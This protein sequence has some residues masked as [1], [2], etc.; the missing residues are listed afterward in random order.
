MEVKLG[1]TEKELNDIKG[2]F[3]QNEGKLDESEKEIVRLRKVREYDEVEMEE[4][5]KLIGMREKEINEVIRQKGY[6]D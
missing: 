5:M 6:E 2:K 3:V 4:K 1:V